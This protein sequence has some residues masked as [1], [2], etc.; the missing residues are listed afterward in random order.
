MIIDASGVHSYIMTPSVQGDVSP[1]VASYTNVKAFLQECMGVVGVEEESQ[2]LSALKKLRDNE[3]KIRHVFVFSEKVHE[4]KQALHD[5][6]DVASPILGRVLAAAAAGTSG[7]TGGSSPGKRRRAKN[8]WRNEKE[9]ESAS[10]HHISS[11]TA[12][13]PRLID[14]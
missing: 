6:V 1:D 13:T 11:H 5:A 3:D 7:K 8:I 4:S 9:S 10:I 2:L 14:D 12:K